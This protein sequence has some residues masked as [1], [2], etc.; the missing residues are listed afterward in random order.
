[1][2]ALWLPL[3]LRRAP[4]FTLNKLPFALGASLLMGLRVSSDEESQGLDIIGHNEVGY[5]L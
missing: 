2:R 1:M 3:L 4:A 5:D